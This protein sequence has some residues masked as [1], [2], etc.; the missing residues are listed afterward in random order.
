MFRSII[1][2]EEVFF[3]NFE[4]IC[5][6]M[7]EAARGLRTMLE[8]G[9][10]YDEAADRIKKLEQQADE[11]THRSI[12]T[13]HKTFVTPLDRQDILRLIVGL[14]D[15]LD[16][17][18]AVSSLLKLYNPRK[19]LPKAADL[20]E[21][22]VRGTE[23]VAVMVG[24]LRQPSKAADRLMALAVELNQLENE[25]DQTYQ[26]AI[27]RLF[28]DEDNSK[29][30]IKWKDILEQIETATDQCEDVADIIEGIVLENA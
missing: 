18:E 25:A 9:A 21:L 2:R 3:D 14:D 28:Q 15:I 16:T 10:P 13:L 8:K 23:K 6:F 27:A 20:A 29:E 26:Q 12:E 30:L 22:L 24:L 11:L 19:I 5:G 17:T 1:P 4:G 7:T